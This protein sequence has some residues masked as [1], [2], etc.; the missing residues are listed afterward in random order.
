MRYKI[1]TQYGNQ[2]LNKIELGLAGGVAVTANT[3]TVPRGSFHQS[4]KM[5]Y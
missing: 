1:I 5:N 2:L 4:E 3:S